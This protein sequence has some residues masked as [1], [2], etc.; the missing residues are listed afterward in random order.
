MQ[1]REMEDG[2]RETKDEKSISEPVPL[3]QILP[4]VMR[5]I[6][7]R[8]EANRKMNDTKF[9][10]SRSWQFNRQINVSVLVQL[11]F[12]ASLI[13]GSWVNLQ[14][15]L[16]LLQHDVTL[17]LQCQKNFDVKLESLSATSI[18]YEYRLRALEK[19]LT[20]EPSTDI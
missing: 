19:A 13:L 20:K 11:V 2:R 12:L 9:E 18:S 4:E 1:S 6:E 10:K 14:R 8:V 15:Q 17:L 16:D 5:N 3:G 7:E